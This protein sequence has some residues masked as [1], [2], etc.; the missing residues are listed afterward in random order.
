MLTPKSF[1]DGTN[2]TNAAAPYYTVPLSTRAIVKKA[3]FCNDDAIPVTV[4]INLVPS[5][6]SAA[7]GNRITKTKALAA[8]ETWSCP[9]VENHVMEAS[10]FISMVASV[11]A[12]IGVRIS[13]Y[14]VGMG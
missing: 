10:G 11:T 5:G 14:E 6:G 9:D 8:G 7:Y 1:V 12:K 3:T 2:L 4:T 13:G